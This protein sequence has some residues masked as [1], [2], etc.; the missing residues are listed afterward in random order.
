VTSHFSPRSSL[1][2]DRLKRLVIAYDGDVCQSFEGK[3]TH[4]VVS[5]DP[6][7]SLPDDIVAAQALRNFEVVRIDWIDAKVQARA[8]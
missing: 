6:G 8:Q 4:V 7:D 1:I 3:P 5:T 2:A